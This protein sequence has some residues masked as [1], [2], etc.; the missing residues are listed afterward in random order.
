MALSHTKQNAFSGE[1]GKASGT[2]FSVP[3]KLYSLAAFL[4]LVVIGIVIYTAISLEKQK[5]DSQ[6]I[7]L[8]GKQRMLIQKLTKSIMELQLGDLSKVEEIKQVQLSFNKVISGLKI[9][10]PELSLPSA[11]T[12]QILF[13]IKNVEKKWELFAEKLEMVFNYAPNIQEDLDFIISNNIPLFDEANQLVNLLGGRMDSKTVS[14]AG[15]LRAITQRVTKATLQFNQF[16]NEDSISE[17][18]KFIV[19]QNKIIDGL[20]NGSSTLNL[21]KVN[22]AKI[23]EKIEVF[24]EHWIEFSDHVETVFNL[25]PVMNTAS[26]Y[27]SENNQDLLE[28]MNVVVQ[29]LSEHSSNKIE[30]MINQEYTILAF[31]LI[32][33]I[34]SVYFLVRSIV[35]PISSATANISSVSNQIVATLEQNERSLS[36]QATAV[37]EITTTMDELDSSAR[38]SNEQADVAASATSLAM[39]KVT[40]GRDTVEKSI[41][42]MASMKEKVDSIATQITRLSDHTNQI[43]NITVLVSDISNQTNLLALNAAVEA[44]RA[45]EHGLG[46]GVVASEIRKLANQ[47]KVSAEKINLLVQ[48]IQ[49]ATDSTVMVTDQGIKTVNEG[50]HFANLISD[51]FNE[52]D[53]SVESIYSNTQQISL[54]ARQQSSAIEQVYNAMKEIN[55]GAQENI[56]GISQT[57]DGIRS[58]SVSSHD[59]KNLID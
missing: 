47:S 28:S 22:D 35:G 56:Q 8:A 45:G 49:T 40:A 5:S 10:D 24:K 53:A 59:L 39:E 6:V 57:K 23:R 44:A 51:V 36:Q 20:L 19:L 34:F 50:T 37:N 18:T 32:G 7:N 3:V 17:G 31:L 26:V 16:R 2:F 15:R 29:E 11:E 12:P 4:F 48:E 58:L 43:S 42:G 1:A 33:G 41:E 21:K 46:F 27:I 14:V 52:V 38:Q 30:R 55:S 9:G 13:K 25:V 54:N